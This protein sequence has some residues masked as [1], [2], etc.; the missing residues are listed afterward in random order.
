MVQPLHGGEEV[1]ERE[2]IRIWMGSKRIRTFPKVKGKASKRL[3]KTIC[4]FVSGSL[5]IYC[6]TELL[7]FIK[8]R[9]IVKQK[10]DMIESLPLLLL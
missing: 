5:K 6:K 3:T 7:K 2:Q 9:L 4:H 10:I 8:K 1:L